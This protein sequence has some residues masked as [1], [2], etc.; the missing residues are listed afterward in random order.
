MNISKKYTI[1]ESIYLSL[2]FIIFLL[3]LTPGVFGEIFDSE[4]WKAWSASRILIYN[5]EFVQLSFGPLYYLMLTILSPLN[6][7][8]SIYFHKEVELPVT[9][10]VTDNL[11][12]LPMYSSLSISEID[13]ISNELN[14]ALD[15]NY[16]NK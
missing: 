1:R 12:T 15:I 16:E 3:I 7:K 9:E 8:F 13:Y 2:L 11:I 4:T 5:G 10:Y 14:N 6:Y